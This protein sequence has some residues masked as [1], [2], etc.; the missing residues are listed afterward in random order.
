MRPRGWF[1]TE[2][3]TRVEAYGNCCDGKHVLNPLHI[4]DGYPLWEGSDLL[5]FHLHQ[6]FYI[7]GFLHVERSMNVEG[8]SNL[9][10]QE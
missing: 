2:W 9:N 8:A 6:S 1:A 5:H 4:R 7:H 10:H 3:T